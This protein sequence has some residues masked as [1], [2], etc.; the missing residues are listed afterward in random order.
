MLPPLSAPARDKV[1]HSKAAWLALGIVALSLLGAGIDWGL[2]AHRSR[3]LDNMVI[4]GR[5]AESGKDLSRA[6]ADVY[7]PL[8]Y[9]VLDV[10]FAPIRRLC[11][12]IE[13]SRRRAGA[14]ILAGRILSS[15]E[16]LGAAL[17][18]AGLARRRFGAGAALPAAGLFLFVPAVVLYGH[19]TN[20]EAPMLWWLS[21]ALFAIDRALV[22]GKVGP[23]LAAFA[24]AAAAVSTKDQAAFVLVGPLAILLWRQPRRGTCGVLVGA[25]VY[26][27]V[28]AV[29]GGW[30]RFAAHYHAMRGN[31]VEFY[32]HGISPSE[33]VKLTGRFAVHVFLAVGPVALLASVFQARRDDAPTREWLVVLLVSA[34]PYALAIVLLAHR[35][36]ARFGLSLLPLAAVLGAP[37]LGGLGRRGLVLLA[38]SAVWAAGISLQLAM[39]P[40]GR[41]RARL[42]ALAEAG[43]LGPRPAVVVFTII[44]G[45]QIKRGPNGEFLSVPAHRVWTMERFGDPLPQPEV[46]AETI[47]Q[48][49]ALGYAD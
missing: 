39:E 19:T 33:L 30:P 42:A 23:T 34:L 2:P 7:P 8:N 49:R 35:S 13:D 45:R 3:A 14:F 26:V 32:T 41:A 18:L 16:L 43:E 44:E 31:A 6:A 4:D 48:L 9:I 15:L 46:D 24:A 40:V 1:G 25:A 47:E 37:V 5:W 22:D 11:G 29:W 21:L 17:L 27:S 38:L 28:F 36:Y 10:L 12:G 20:A